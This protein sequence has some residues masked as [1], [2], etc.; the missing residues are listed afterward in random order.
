[1]QRINALLAAGFPKKHCSLR[2]LMALLGLRKAQDYTYL[3]GNYLAG[4]VNE[5]FSNKPSGP[6]NGY[7]G[8]L[9]ISDAIFEFADLSEEN[10]NTL[11]GF[12]YQQLHTVACPD[13]LQAFLVERLGL[14]TA[15]VGPDELEPL[16]KLGG[17]DLAL[18]M[19]AQ[20]MFADEQTFRF[21]AKG[22]LPDHKIS[23]AIEKYYKARGYTRGH[24]TP[25]EDVGGYAGN[26]FVAKD[27]ALVYRIFFTNFT[28]IPA[29]R[30]F[31]LT[32]NAA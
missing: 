28:R 27:G 13:S 22:P 2:V 19:A 5:M 10:A 32:I 29:L 26:I 8:F 24:N 23:D 17:T 12:L 7:P 14:S 18:E 6:S 30:G 1:M 16:V 15:V 11:K 3:S 21:K 31:N 20:Q 9:E 4:A 25:L